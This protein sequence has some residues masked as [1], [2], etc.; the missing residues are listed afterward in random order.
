MKQKPKQNKLK[1]RYQ[2]PE[3]L[4]HQPLPR[5]RFTPTAWAKLRY[6]CHKGDTE[7]GGFGIS[8]ADDLLLIE[9]FALIQQRA[10]EVIVAFEDDAVAEFFDQQVDEGKKPAQFARVWLHTHPGN[11]PNPSAVDEETFARVFGGCDWAVMFILARGGRSYC[12]LRCN[13]GPG[14]SQLIHVEVDY[15]QPFCA[16]DFVAW[17][18]EYEANV[19]Q[20]PWDLGMAA[21]EADWLGDEELWRDAE[22]TEDAESLLDQFAYEEVIR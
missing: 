20:V 22:L 7:I 21:T 18:A 1:T 8:A 5:L 6:L 10:S 17:D 9:E 15:D 2:E 3:P 16:A 13:V 4:R 11:C 12:R 19:N 14:L